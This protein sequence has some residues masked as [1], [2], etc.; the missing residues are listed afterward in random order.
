MNDRATLAHQ[1]QAGL[2]RL[3]SH[4]E[5]LNTGTYTDFTDNDVVPFLAEQGLTR[6]G[7]PEAQGGLGGTTV[8][9]VEALADVAEQ[10]LAAAFVMWGHRCMTDMLLQTDNAALR[11]RLLP[12]LL[13]GEHAGATGL[14]NAMKFLGGIEEL[15]LQATANTADGNLAAGW[16][17]QGRMHWVTNLRPA[18]FTVAAAVQ[19]THEAPAAV[20][21]LDSNLLGMQRSANLDL[22]GM[23]GSHTAAIDVQ[24]V[25]VGPEQLLHADAKAFLP[26]IR[27]NFLSL[28]CGMSIG[29]ARA[30]L[31]AAQRHACGPRDVLGERIAQVSKRLLESTAQMYE[32][33]QQGTFTTQPAALFKLRIALAHQVQEA[34][35][36]ELQACGG[37]A[38]LVGQA[39]GFMRRWLEAAFIPLITPSLSQL[40]FQLQAQ[41]KAALSQG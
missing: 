36:L 10:S 33:L 24:Q 22:Q 6:I 9:V 19:P 31:A 4:A 32:G 14:S 35:A 15:Q 37:R 30:S 5:A 29:L 38:Y 20:F 7:V 13:A 41:K 3:A 12:S 27:P 40:E 26:R 1:R 17:I 28:Q 11:E 23:R 16:R 8:D 2:K 25:P 18:G 39:P 21:A 34:I